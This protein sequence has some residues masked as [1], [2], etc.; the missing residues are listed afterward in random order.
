MAR[1]TN[2]IRLP[3]VT[4]AVALLAS[5]A[6]AACDGEGRPEILALATGGTGG[7]YYVLGG[8]M[9]ELWSRQLPEGDFVAEVTGVR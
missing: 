3:S 5:L 2:R 8:A 9:A 4:L 6:G 1:E 7:V